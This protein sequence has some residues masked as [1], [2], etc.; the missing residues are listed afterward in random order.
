MQAVMREFPGELKRSLAQP[1]IPLADIT[2]IQ[3]L[4]IDR[5]VAY[6]E[7]G[8]KKIPNVIEI[9]YEHDPRLDVDRLTQDYLVRKNNDGVELAPFERAQLLGI[10]L[11]LN[12]GH[13]DSRILR[14]F[15]YEVE[16][17]RISPEIWYYR[18]TTK[19]RQGKEL[20]PQEHAQLDDLKAIRRIQAITAVL[21]ARRQ[22]S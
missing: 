19:E 6:H 2:C 16:E 17:A 22:L 12:D 14:H 20:T 3:F 4:P 5:P 10:T 13:I 11:A 1:G 21:T 18:L 8:E 9:P 7:S 15:G